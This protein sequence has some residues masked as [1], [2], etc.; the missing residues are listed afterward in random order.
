LRKRLPAAMAGSVE[1]AKAFLQQAS[2][3]DGYN[4]YDHL[5]SALTKLLDERP[6]NAVD[7][8]EDLSKQLKPGKGGSLAPEDAA[9]LQ[10]V[11][12]LAT[13]QEKLFK[14]V[15]GE[16][17]EQDEDVEPQI[18][19]VM[20]QSQY[21]EDAG[22]GL[23]REEVFRIYL[24]MKQLQTQ[25]QFRKLRFWGKMFGIEQSYIIVECEY[26]E[27]E[28]PPGPESEEADAAEPEDGE[29]DG[30]AIDDTPK[31]TYVE[32]KPTPVEAYPLGA[33][34]YV[35]YVCTETGAQW[36]KLPDATPKQIVVARQIKKFLT[37]DLSTVIHSY[38]PFNGTEA[39]Y[40][41]AQ[42]AQI[43]C[44][45]VISPNGYFTFGDEEEEDEPLDTF[46][47]NAEFE[48]LKRKQLEDPD[49][50]R[51]HIADI[52]D[53]G[54]CKWWNPNTKGDDE[55]DEDEDEDEAADVVVPETG[56]ALLSS[57]VA[58]ASVD[59]FAAW[60]PKLTTQKAGF[61]GVVMC[62][63]RWP[64]AFSL[65]YN[66]GKTFQNTYVGWG[67]KYEASTYS[68]PLPA[69]AEA[70]Y[71]ADEGILETTDPT[72][73]EVKDFNEKNKEDKDDDDDDDDEYN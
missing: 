43:S 19:D 21:F 51:H 34:K 55:E 60:T 7:D 64:G 20:K 29:Q 72:P 47:V 31:S 17:A 16:D 54:R 18:D 53:Q 30:E 5:K 58:D 61:G 9:L 38:P 12:E 65:A 15:E 36:V 27:G 46:E 63:N 68:Q 3:T 22:V 71:V 10:K 57:V 62:S 67:H 24:S 49:N 25:F 56:R 1:E 70:E 44:D 2:N 73:Q 69:S 23:G 14:P 35:Y 45:C 66:K 11:V 26:A 41:R 8:F 32:P 33:N 6:D 40:L 52:L 50:W 48:G 42:I 13:S 37:G 59:G 28:E 4:L 39:E